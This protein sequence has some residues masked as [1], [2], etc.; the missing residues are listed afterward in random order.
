M[1]HGH[2]SDGLWVSGVIA[3]AQ[4]SVLI[5]IP[6]LVVLLPV[7]LARLVTTVPAAITAIRREDA[8]GDGT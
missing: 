3:P 4:T 5:V 1:N 2:V 8:T 7:T 6:V